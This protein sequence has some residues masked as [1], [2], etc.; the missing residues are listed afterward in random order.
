MTKDIIREKAAALIKDIEDC[1]LDI[2]LDMTGTFWN[3]YENLKA[4]L[5]PSREDIANTLGMYLTWADISLDTDGHRDI[6]R[7]H[8][9]YAIE[10]LRRN[11]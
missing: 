8:I 2:E 7:K 4:S 9:R 1:E 5:R 10:E 6:F 11:D 3:S